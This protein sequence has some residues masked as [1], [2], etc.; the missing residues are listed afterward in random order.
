M[1]V[2]YCII[3]K[4][5]H[6]HR[7]NYGQPLLGSPLF[8]QHL[9]SYLTELPP[10]EREQAEVIYFILV[11]ESPV[12]TESFPSIDDLTDKQ[13][14][15]NILFSSFSVN[16]TTYLNY[17]IEGSTFK[18]EF[19]EDSHKNTSDQQRGHSQKAKDSAKNQRQDYIDSL[20]PEIRDFLSQPDIVTDI[21]KNQQF[22][23]ESAE[24][25]IKAVQRVIENN[26]DLIKN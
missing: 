11:H 18:L 12:L 21:F 22:L 19:E 5:F 25:F 14:L 4:T 1:I 24:V 13:A 15:L 6:I 23:E 20:P 3:H 8:H 2:C 16:P 7:A 10:Q 17:T 26:P 9:M